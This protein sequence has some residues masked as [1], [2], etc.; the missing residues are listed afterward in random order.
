MGSVPK[1]LRGPRVPGRQQLMNQAHPHKTCVVQHAQHKRQTTTNKGGQF[2]VDTDLP[3]DASSVDE[4]VN[5]GRPHDF[6]DW[7]GQEK[8]VGGDFRHVCAKSSGS[9]EPGFGYFADSGDGTSSDESGPDVSA[10]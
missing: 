1:V 6:F 5:G 10:T 8:M 2:T 4:A 3:T 9:D 7:I